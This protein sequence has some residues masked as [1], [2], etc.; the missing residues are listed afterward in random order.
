LAALFPDVPPHDP[1]L[2]T[3]ARRVDA[4]LAASAMALEATAFVSADRAFAGVKGLRFVELAGLD[5]AALE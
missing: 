1:V 2:E 5:L 3:S 4:V